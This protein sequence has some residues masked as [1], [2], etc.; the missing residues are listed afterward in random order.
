MR[1]LITSNISAIS[2]DVS[3][4]VTKQLNQETK[5]NTHQ[6]SSMGN[7]V[8]LKQIDAKQLGLYGF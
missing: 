5:N 1:T 2:Y 6:F 8:K 3:Y 7:M 4:S